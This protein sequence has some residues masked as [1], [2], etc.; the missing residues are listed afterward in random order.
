MT[1]N[2]SA[3]ERFEAGKKKFDSGDYL[4]AITEFETIKLQFP[5]SAVADDAAYLDAECRFRRGE[6]LLAAE[7][8]Q[9]LRRNMPSSPFVP[10]AQYKTALCYYELAPKTA[11]DQ[12]YTERAIDEFQSFIDY[13]P[14]DTNVAAAETRITELNGRLAERLY[15]TA[16]LYMNMEYYKSATIY[17]N[18]VIEKYHDTPFAE[19]A[20]LGKVRSLVLRKR[21]D[22]ARE[23]IGKFLTK[24][25]QSPLRKDAESL[26]NEIDE[27]LR[28]TSAA[29]P[30][31][32]A[33]R[34]G[35]AR[36]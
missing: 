12:K 34:T 4:E 27:H 11:L 22:E 19:P 26:R 6:Y 15:K 36:A 16:Q 28:G 32:H 1:Q 9:A 31:A 18:S 8:Y 3:E 23:E 25:P 29:A 10:L 35:G 30:A 13:Y 21:Y 5:G 24:Y 2:L 14:K 33:G 7:E 20:L 17:F